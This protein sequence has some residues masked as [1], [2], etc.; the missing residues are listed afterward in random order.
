MGK[1]P[2]RLSDP[3]PI[4]LDPD[5]EILLNA[6]CEKRGEKKAEV[7]RRYV[8]EAAE[9]EMALTFSADRLL[10][11][12]RRAVAETSKPFEERMAKL[13]AKSS[14]ASATTMYTNLE[15]LGQLGKRDVREIHA[16]A[17]AKA[18]SFVRSSKDAG[19]IKE[20][21]LSGEDIE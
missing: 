5:T 15:V 20:S 3:I 13:S 4:R 8:K 18:V 10:T 12:V 14:I 21:A 7:I 9:A 16:E 2:K 1:A 19:D 11:L 17:R 6:I